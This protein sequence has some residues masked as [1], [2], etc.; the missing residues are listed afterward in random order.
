MDEKL[1]HGP[2][3]NSLCRVT[4]NKNRQQGMTWRILPSLDTLLKAAN[5]AP[6]FIFYGK[7][8]QLVFGLRFLRSMI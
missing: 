2:V 8:S 6:S 3:D 4:I 7:L 1:I 5:V